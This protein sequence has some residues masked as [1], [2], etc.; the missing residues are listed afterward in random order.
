MSTVVSVDEF[1]RAVYHRDN[2]KA[3]QQLLML[4]LSY[5]T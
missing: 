4:F 3:G 5:L 2:E 1:E